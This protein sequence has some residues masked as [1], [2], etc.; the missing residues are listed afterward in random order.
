MAAHTQFCR[1]GDCTYEA[2]TAAVRAVASR[3]AATGAAIRL[4]LVISDADLARYGKHPAE[5]DRL[6]TAD[7]A[8]HAVALLIASRAAEAQAIRDALSPGKVWPAT[9][10]PPRPASSSR[11]IRNHDNHTQS[12]CHTPG[13]TPRAK[14]TSLS[15]PWEVKLMM[16]SNAELHPFICLL[17]FMDLIPETAWT[18]LTAVAK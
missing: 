5:W 9:N 8:V 12:L 15:L 3:G 16:A 13:Q 17:Q 10:R 18:M 6:L 4:V 11:L 7:P 1:P 2:T 14:T